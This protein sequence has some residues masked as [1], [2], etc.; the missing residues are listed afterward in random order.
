MVRQARFTRLTVRF[1]SKRQNAQHRTLL[2]LCCASSALAGPESPSRSFA[3][4]LHTLPTLTKSLSCSFCPIRE[5]KWHH[6]LVIAQCAFVSFA[7]AN[8]QI[9]RKTALRQF[10]HIS[11]SACIAREFARLDFDIRF[12]FPTFRFLSCD[13]SHRNVSSC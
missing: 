10:I 1:T 7:S 4:S 3:V 9:D 12:C 2:F 13:V 8:A 5:S 6:T 11:L